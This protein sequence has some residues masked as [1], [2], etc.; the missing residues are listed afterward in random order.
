MRRSLR[1]ELK[2][3]RLPAKARVVVPPEP[4]NACDLG[5]GDRSTQV[6]AA[7]RHRASSQEPC[8]TGATGPGGL[9]I[10]QSVTYSSPT[11]R[12]SQEAAVPGELPDVEVFRKEAFL[13][14]EANASLRSAHPT[15][16]EDDEMEW[17]VGSDNVAVFHNF[18]EDEERDSPRGHAHLAAQEVRCR[19]RH[20]QLARRARR[21]GPAVDLP[22]GLQHRRGQVRHPERRGAA[23]DLDGAHRHHG[24]GLRHARAEA[25]VDR[26]AHAHGRA[27][28]PAVQRAVGRLRPGL[29]HHPGRARR[30]RVGAERPEGV[31]LG[32]APS[33]TGAWP[34]PGPTSTCPS[35]AA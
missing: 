25:A 5:H 11:P 4:A 7:E 26:A 22:A 23:A 14:L 28:V 12:R 29:A 27:G 9:R 34:S 6:F 19:L 2:R 17:G 21:A 33:P 30:R 35:T 24:R 31:D 8:H 13:W 16:G 1:S 32:S 20:D 15:D 10:D 3:R 18:S